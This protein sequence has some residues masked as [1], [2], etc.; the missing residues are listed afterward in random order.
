MDLMSIVV[1]NVFA[2]FLVLNGLLY[3]TFIT[4]VPYTFL[5]IVFIVVGAVL[6]PLPVLLVFLLNLLAFLSLNSK[7]GNIERMVA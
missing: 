7:D 5:N 4:Q 1:L 2:M 6:W 3:F